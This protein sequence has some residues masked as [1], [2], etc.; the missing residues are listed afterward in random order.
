MSAPAAAPD[1]SAAVPPLPE[2][3]VAA[4]PLGGGRP[5]WQRHPLFK[6]FSSVKLA[7]VLIGVIIVASIAGT[8]YESSFDAKVARAYIYQAWW[9]N[10]WLTALCL[11]LICSAFS[12]WPWK[13][14]HTGFLITH[15]GIVTLL[16]GAMIGR[17]WGVEGSITL[18][19]GQPP[20]NQLIMDQR[21]LRVEEAGV[22]P[23]QYPV[24]IIGRRPSP[25]HPWSLGETAS[26]WNIQLMDYAP[27][28]DATFEPQAAPPE[29]KELA[30]PAVRVKL[31]TQ[32]V[33]ATV[34]QWLLAGDAD[35]G[36]LDLSG[37]AG[38]ELRRGVAPEIAAPAAG[39]EAVA[40]PRAAAAAAPAATGMAAAPATAA[41]DAKSV[42]EAFLAMALNPAQGISI[43]A[44][45]SVPSGAT[46][47]LNVDAAGGKKTVSVAW[48]GAT[49]DFDVDSER[50]K[51]E[52]LSGSGL[53]VRVENYWPDFVMK[54]GK[55]ATASA[56]PR[57]PAVLV[58]VTGKLPAGSTDEPPVA[59][60]P[61]TA[62]PL[63]PGVP[64]PM[65]AGTQA[66]NQVVL[67]CDDQGNLTYTLKS[68]ADPG[69]QRGTLKPGE[70]IPTGWMDWRLEVVQAVPAALARTTFHPA[71]KA[72][73]QTNDQS[74]TSGDP[75]VVAGGGGGSVDGMTAA[76]NRGQGLL[77]R[78]S[79]GGQSLEQWA[80][81][82][83]QVT[84]PT[85]PS[86]T[87]LAYD[88]QV[89]GLPI[90]LQLDSFEVGFNEGTDS[91]A[92]FKSTLKATDIE[93][94]SGQGSCSM[95]QP[96]NFPGHWWNTFSGLTYKMSQAQWNPQDTNQST[97]QILRDPGWML[98]WV[99]SLLICAG[100]FTLFYLR[101]AKV[102]IKPVAQG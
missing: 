2:T 73:P 28:I 76:V 14:H 7:V 95:N 68:R 80:A 83:W 27:L 6:L 91:P 50:G 90:G 29:M 40:A 100:V 69:G 72:L 46:V 33:G 61:Q 31:V 84:L 53:S 71:A 59:S 54:D 39:G 18:T 9:F 52:D 85:T 1:H 55:P 26:G 102:P 88:F 44:E 56:D 75:R 92:S 63:A 34:D 36:T 87:R 11:N 82:G 47:S 79:K 17:R 94:N 15:L 78:L 42:N 98:K 96:F 65:G 99:G 45:G 24:E 30:Q 51:D 23:R 4:R 101:P 37:L 66:G 58:R 81:T 48:R 74:A 60:T 13:R 89:D 8:L 21:V 57:N 93:G 16:I 86:P 67:Y 5:A 10:L 70:P 38:V 43:P 12:R 25:A 35:H 20:S 19:K 3:P 41:G 32:R 97:I 49:W 22:E 77:V 64:P 62:P